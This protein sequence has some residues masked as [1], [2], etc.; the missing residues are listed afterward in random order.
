M[1]RKLAAALAL[2]VVGSSAIACPSSL[3]LKGTVFVETCDPHASG[4][5]NASRV[6]YEYAEAAVDRPAV[7]TV[8][9]QTSPWH[10]YD[11]HMRI[12]SI[13]DFAAQMRPNLKAPVKSIDLQ[14]SWTSVAPDKD[15]KSL[16]DQLSTALNHYPVTGEDG[17]AWFSK[18]GKVR[19]THEAFTMRKG[20]GAYG[21]HS[22]D[23]VMSSL[24]SGWPAFVEDEFVK[25]GNAEGE[26]HAAAGWDIFFLCPD[27][28]LAS[29]E[30]AAEMGNAIAA[31]D[32]AMMRLE[33]GD[34]ADRKAAIV[35][36]GRAVKLG[37]GK[38]KEVLE[39]LGIAA[40]G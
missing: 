31:Y 19:T 34:E 2:L 4:C 9:V 11:E 20:G 3:P 39:K 7:L 12:V 13:E 26:L 24:A 8:Q 29:F 21:V 37:D 36:L 16:V 38:A 28:A 10:I 25:Q 23:D 35:L 5:K 6:L 40:D 33:R 14:G 15:H 30:R 22:G 1:S 18:D 27:H 32:A 17:F